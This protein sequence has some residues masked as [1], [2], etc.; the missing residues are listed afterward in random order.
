MVKKVADKMILL[1]LMYRDELKGREGCNPDINIEQKDNQTQI[2]IGQRL[3]TQTKNILDLEIVV[4]EIMMT[5]LHFQE[6]GIV[7]MFLI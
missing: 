6:S 5:I 3:M 2:H 7:I 4:V 1:M